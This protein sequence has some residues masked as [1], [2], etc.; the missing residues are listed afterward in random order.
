VSEM[1][2]PITHELCLLMHLIHTS[3]TAS[4]LTDTVT[5]T[6][7]INPGAVYIQRRRLVWT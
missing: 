3:Q 7:S 2:C 4:N 6:H 5:Q 1:Q